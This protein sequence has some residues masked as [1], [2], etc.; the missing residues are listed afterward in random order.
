[1]PNTNNDN[2]Q[3]SENGDQ[4]TNTHPNE[5]AQVAQPSIIQAKANENTRITKL[6]DYLTDTNYNTWKGQ[7]ML[8]LEIC[9]AEKYA[10][11][12]ENEPNAETD[13]L[14]FHNWEFNN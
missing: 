7:M 11:G 3:S 9:G 10:I 14:G 13:R 1:M 4:P 12:T 6:N 5:L 8:T 2:F